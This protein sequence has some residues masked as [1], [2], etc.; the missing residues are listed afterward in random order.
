MKSINI[1]PIISHTAKNLCV[2]FIE[3]IYGR[4]LKIDFC[5][6]SLLGIFFY[7]LLL[8]LRYEICK[9][10]NREQED[11]PCSLAFYPFASAKVK[12]LNFS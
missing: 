3:V 10:A 7:C 9:S 6:A 5:F 12:Y 2:F 8:E 11:S 1:D 4:F